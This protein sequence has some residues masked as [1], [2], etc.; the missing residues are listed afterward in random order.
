MNG[1]RFE[2]ERRGTIRDHTGFAAATARR[3]W[4]DAAALPCALALVG[5]LAVSGCASDKGQPAK[6]S[7]P[8]AAAP[9]PNA[10]PPADIAAAKAKPWTDRFL[11][12]GVL[13]ADEVRIEGP[14]PL[15]EHVVTRPEAGAH[16]TRVQTIPAGLEQTIV[17]RTPGAEIRGQIDQLAISALRRVVILE[18]PGVG[19]VLVTAV[20][21]VFWKDGQTGKETRAQSVR[22][23]GPIAR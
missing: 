16:E 15:L 7:T 4:L 19:D 5:C 1:Y 10:A 21:D 9:D 6:S 3:G 18:R 20:G 17:V 23:E 14:K 8:F 12:P 2:A 13:V 11:G 22:I